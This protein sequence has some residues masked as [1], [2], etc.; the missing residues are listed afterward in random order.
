MSPFGMR[1][2]TMAVRSTTYRLVALTSFP[3][4]EAPAEKTIAP[5]YELVVHTM[6]VLL[7]SLSQPVGLGCLSRLY[8]SISIA[9]SS[10]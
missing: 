8:R 1:L 3:L 2:A 7:I 10:C 9:S 6:R 5:G 4:E